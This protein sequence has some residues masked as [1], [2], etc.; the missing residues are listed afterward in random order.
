[1]TQQRR[2]AAIICGIARG[3]FDHL[4]G[5]CLQRQWHGKA[6]GLCDLEID[7]QLK[8]G[9]EF[10]IICYAKTVRLCGRPQPSH[11]EDIDMDKKIAGLLG[12]AATLASMDAALAATTAA[13]SPADTMRVASYAELL[14]PIP[15]AVALLIANDAVRT[16]SPAQRVQLAGHHH[17]HRYRRQRS[18]HHHHH[19]NYMAIPRATT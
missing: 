10:G 4:V 13:P 11:L 9:L 19:S 12:A 14:A 3:S 17:H 7:D 15:N 5:G 1:M 18:R 8:R 16:Q 6:K 2:F